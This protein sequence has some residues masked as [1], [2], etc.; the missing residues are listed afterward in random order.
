M[1]LAIISHKLC[2]SR[3]YEKCPPIY[4]RTGVDFGEEV[5]RSRTLWIWSNMISYATGSSLVGVYQDFAGEELQAWM[6]K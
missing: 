1:G 2:V 4:P 5:C 3:S 6:K